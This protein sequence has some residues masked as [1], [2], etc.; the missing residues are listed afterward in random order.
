M[1]IRLLGLPDETAQAVDL[2]AQTF[3]VI[4]VSDP[5]PMR[6]ASRQ[7]RVYIEIRLPQKRQDRPVP[8]RSA[9]GPAP[10]TPERTHPTTYTLSVIDCDAGPNVR[11]QEFPEWLIAHSKEASWEVLA[12]LIAIGYDD[13]KPDWWVLITPTGED[14]SALNVIDSRSNIAL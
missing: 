3:D 9:A 6:G 12:W 2:L 1:K 5:Y 13:S 10:L 8:L 11:G 7:V 4:D 14:P